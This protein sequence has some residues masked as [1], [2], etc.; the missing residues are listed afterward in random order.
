M[1]RLLA[2]C[3]L[4][5]GLAVSAAMA[6]EAVGPGQG[7]DTPAATAPAPVAAA[8][9]GAPGDIP[10]QPAPKRFAVPLYGQPVAAKVDLDALHVREVI[11][12]RRRDDAGQVLVGARVRITNTGGTA[13]TPALRVLLYRGDAP[14]GAVVFPTPGVPAAEMAP[15]ATAS[16]EGFALADVKALP[17]GFALAPP[18]RVVAGSGRV[19]ERENGRVGERESGRV[20]D[21]EAGMSIIHI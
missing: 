18:E 20:G 21:G 13:L 7:Q 9:A 3:V 11:L 8:P 15:G 2:C 6:Q 10:A 14:A 12:M 4:A 16:W 17:D 5:G 1:C 19:G